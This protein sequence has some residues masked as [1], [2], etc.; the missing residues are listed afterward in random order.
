MSFVDRVAVVIEGADVE[1][2]DFGGVEIEGEEAVDA[3]VEDAER[4][5]FGMPTTRRRWAML[6]A[7]YGEGVGKEVK[8]EGV[9][10]ARLRG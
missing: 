6:S 5:D 2:V 4:R 10:V 3:D 1:D 9:K 7:G 8:G